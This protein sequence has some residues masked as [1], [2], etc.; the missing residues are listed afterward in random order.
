[1]NHHNH[2]MSH[3]ISDSNA[4]DDFNKIFTS[5]VN[6]APINRVYSSAS[7]MHSMSFHFG[8]N[9]IVLFSFWVVTSPIGIITTC[10]L[11]ILMCFIMEGIRWFRGIRPPYN[12]D[13]HTEQSSVASLKF[14]PR[15]TTAM[16]TDAILHAIQLTLSYVLMLLFMT[17]N[18]WICAA[19]VF[20]EVSARLIFAVLFSKERIKGNRADVG[21]CT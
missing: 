19:T 18:V 10:A 6:S 16:C 13:L 7:H 21:C 11:T 17:F 8:S 12:V 4:S 3:I 5:A 9:E 14:A 2:H 20:G 1:M 15:I